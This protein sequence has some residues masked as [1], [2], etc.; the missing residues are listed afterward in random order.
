[1]NN[2]ILAVIGIIVLG[3]ITIMAF[4]VDGL[5]GFADAITF[6][7]ASFQ[8]YIDLVISI[9]IISFWIYRDANARG[10]N[11]WPWIIAAY[12]VGVFSPLAYIIMREEG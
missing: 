5:I 3:I 9:T 12:I 10:K 7:W 11:P 1:M 8:I 2:R 6:S 4:W